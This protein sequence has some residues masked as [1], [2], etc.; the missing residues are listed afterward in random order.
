MSVHIGLLFSAS[1][2]HFRAHRKNRK[3]SRCK[4]LKIRRIRKKVQ[5]VQKRSD[6]EKRP[7]FSRIFLKKNPKVLENSPMQ[8]EKQG[9]STS[10]KLTGTLALPPTRIIIIISLPP[11]PQLCHTSHPWVAPGYTCFAHISH[12]STFSV[13]LSVCGWFCRRWL[14]S[15]FGHH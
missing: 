2:G 1:R 15:V 7:I 8:F 5:K 13:C 6:L 12:S 9:P 10:T 3:Q 14:L 11:P 4:K